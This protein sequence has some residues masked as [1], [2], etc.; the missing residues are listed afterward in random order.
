MFEKK[1]NQLKIQDL[2]SQ[3]LYQQKKLSLPGIGI[4]DLNPAVNIYELKEEGW[5]ENTVTFTQDRTAQLTDD[6]LNYLVQNSGKMKPLAMS[7]LESYLNNGIQLLNIGKPFPLKGIGSLSKTGNQYFFE[8]GS[9]VVEKLESINPD[10]IL[11]DRTK[12]NEDTKELDFTSEGRANSKKIIIALGSLVALAL[13]AWVVY[14]ALPKKE[15]EP[16]VTNEQQAVTPPP[17]ITQTVTDT[18]KTTADT[19]KT[20]LPDTVKTMPVAPPTVNGTGFQLIIQTFFTK[21]AADKKLNSLLA[22]GHN[23]SVQMVDSTRYRL[24]LTVAKPLS[25]TTYVKDSLRRWYLWKAEL[26]Q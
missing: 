18:V 16:V 12:K 22:R 13:I 21:A 7:D 14:L 17:S 9:P 15:A 5:P 19:T 10:Y 6:C 1:F 23:V 11:K 26:L 3:Y 8:Q 2:L 20:L 25:D 4:F 24:V